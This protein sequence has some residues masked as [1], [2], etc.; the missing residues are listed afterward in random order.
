MKGL[1]SRSQWELSLP[2]FHLKFRSFSGPRFIPLATG[3]VRSASART[4]LTT[5]VRVQ[6]QHGCGTELFLA[7]SN[8]VA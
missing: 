3:E 6:N 7:F 8:D 1:T 5:Q 4:S 2:R